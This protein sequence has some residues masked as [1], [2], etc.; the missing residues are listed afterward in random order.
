MATPI[1]WGGEF[2]VNTTT[3]SI[4]WNNA[5]A[6]LADG[7]FVVAWSDMSGRD[8]TTGEGSQ[9]RAQVFGAD[10]R[11]DGAEIVAS[12]TQPSWSSVLSVTARAD[13]GFVLSW[14]GEGARGGDG[15]GPGI[16]ARIFGPGGTAPGAEILVNATVSDVQWAPSA[17]VLADGRFVVAWTDGSATGGDT[18]GTAIRAQVFRSDGTRQ[19]PEV[20]VNTTTS[21]SQFGPSVTGLADG[22]FLVAWTDE[23]QLVWGDTVTGVAVRGRVFDAA[24][25]PQGAEFTLSTTA[26]AVHSDVQATMLADGRLAVAWATYSP[27]GAGGYDYEIFGRVLG[28]DG[29]PQGPQIPINATTAGIQSDPA[30]AA[31]PDGGFAVAWWDR[32]AE[33]SGPAADAVRLRVF[34]ADGMPRGGDMVVTTTTEGEQRMPAIAALADGRLVVSWDD[35]SQT[36]GDP[37]GGGIRARIVDPRTAAVSLNGTAGDDDLVGT[38]FADRI[39]GSAGRDEVSGAAGDDRLWGEEGRDALD[40]GAGADRI[41]GGMGRDTLSGG[42]DDDRLAG[43]EGR[44]ALDGGMGRDRLSGG[45]AM[46][47]LAGGEGADTLDGGAGRDRL[48]GGEGA[49]VFVFGPGGGRDRVTDWEDGTDRLDLRVFGFDAAREVL[50]LAVEVGDDLVFRFA[51]GLTL[52]LEDAARADLGAADLIL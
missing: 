13:G 34:D 5:V 47:A 4:Q 28:P 31:L 42:A 18:G 48:A 20:L 41:A 9:I 6:A 25:A 36:G 33:A 1:G 3:D 17:R 49:D 24:G 46:D 26:A 11:P 51:P 37:T 30:V 44:D 15:D 50:R 16:R 35:G 10:G 29:A 14:A 22:G 19:G 40:G 23:S 45:R 39:A 52:T 7:R 8:W 2:P 27:N 12:L 32:G 38:V 21:G 43:Q